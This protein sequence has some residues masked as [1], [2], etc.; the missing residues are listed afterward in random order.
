M[1]YRDSYRG[2]NLP[3]DIKAKVV[4]VKSKS[5]SQYDDI[6]TYNGSI[7]SKI[8]NLPNNVGE[9]VTSS[10]FNDLLAVQK[11]VLHYGT[12]VRNHMQWHQSKKREWSTL[13]IRYFMVDDDSTENLNM[14]RMIATNRES[15]IKFILD[16]LDEILDLN[17]WNKFSFGTYRRMIDSFVP[18]IRGGWLEDWEEFIGDQE[19]KIE[20]GNIMIG[21]P[22]Q[23]VVEDYRTREATGFQVV[24]STNTEL[25]PILDE[26]VKVMQIPLPSYSP[27]GSFTIGMPMKSADVPVVKDKMSKTI[28]TSVTRFNS[29]NHFSSTGQF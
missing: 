27:I 2:S 3:S 24:C 20:K 28:D 12:F 17:D 19:E 14:L 25:R 1:S 4:G 26:E 8:S 29:R 13:M 9:T 10:D 15:R 5:S 7:Y 11:K 6:L 18:S 21:H 16:Y 23:L 22:V